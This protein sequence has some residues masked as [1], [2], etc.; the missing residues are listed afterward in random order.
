MNLF[1]DIRLDIGDDSNLVIPSGT[2]V[3]SASYSSSSGNANM[4][5]DIRIDIGD[6]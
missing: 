4:L 6:D 3:G 2:Y 5:G 1:W